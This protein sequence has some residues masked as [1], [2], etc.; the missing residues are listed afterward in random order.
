MGL[1]IT[2]EGTMTKWEIPLSG[3]HDPTWEDNTWIAG[4]LKQ[5]AEKI[6]EENPRIIN[7]GIRTDCDYKSVKFFID[8]YERKPNEDKNDKRSVATE[9]DSSTSAGNI[10][11]DP[12]ILEA[13]KDWCEE[14]GEAQ[15]SNSGAMSGEEM[16]GEFR[17]IIS[18][19]FLGSDTSDID[20]ETFDLAI[21]GCVK[22][23]AS[24]LKQKEDE[25]MELKEWKKSAIKVMP[26]IQEIG[27]T[28]GVKLGESIHDKILPAIQELQSSV[29][30]YRK[31]ADAAEECYELLNLGT[32][33]VKEYDNWQ[34]LKQQL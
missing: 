8:L 32:I 29:D 26:P 30:K 3:Y 7:F 27:K 10:K 33:H 25:I 28:I 11:T 18:H 20:R 17:S 24:L 34:T 23:A 5:L 15:K 9:V 13:V 4:H 6:E 22:Y 16:D 12:E 1:A 31:L 2:R 19:A 14:M 21:N